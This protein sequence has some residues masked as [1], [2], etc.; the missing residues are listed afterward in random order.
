MQFA[1]ES[2]FRKRLEEATAQLE[3]HQRSV[4]LNN[5]YRV[6]SFLMVF[7]MFFLLKGLHMTLA[8]V[9][10]FLMLIAFVFL[11][12]RSAELVE[13]VAFAKS[14]IQFLQIQLRTIAGDNSEVEDGKEYS[15]PDHDF[16]YDLDMFGSGSV[17]QMI[18]R[19]RLRTGKS[20]LANWLTHNETDPEVICSRQDAIQE[21]SE[22]LPWCEE[23]YA[24]ADVANESDDQLSQL[25]S[26]SKSKLAYQPGT[27]EAIAAWLVPVYQVAIL[28]A[29]LLDYLSAG[30]Y[31]VLLLAPLSWIGK[32]IRAINEAYSQ[33]GDQ[34]GALRYY[35]NMFGHT[36]KAEFSSSELSKL[37]QP[38]KEASS[39][40]LGLS[41]IMSAFDNRNNMLMGVILN[42]FLW[43]DIRCLLKLDRWQQEHGNAIEGWLNNLGEWEA[44][45]SFGVFAYTFAE[46]LHYP[47]P[48]KDRLSIQKVGHPLMLTRKRVDNDFSTEYGDFSII[49]GANMAGK[50]TFLRTLGVNMILAMAGAP[51]LAESFSFR[52][53]KLYSSM[54]TSDSLQSDESYFYNELKR[55]KVLIDKLESGEE[56][57]IILDEILKGTNSK[58]K[59]EGSFRFVEKLLQ[60]KASGVVA[61]HDLSL[62]ELENHHRTRIH[63]L[64]FDVE[65]RNDDLYFDYTLR[66]G[67]CSNMNATFLMKKMNIV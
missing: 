43:W 8:I 41:K 65:I 64:F 37:Q 14:V 60:Y 44:L 59:A 13:R 58:D 39:A 7:G 57:F 6:V 51:V 3:R 36:Q 21:L 45:S 63:N 10:A 34:E 48:K 40:L 61:T 26:W 47:N 67:I 12:R 11:V 1:S 54:R 27:A 52:P 49:T 56:R 35:A 25:L 9:V 22:N 17:F 46:S 24:H 29:Y 38:G 23:L 19:A 4:L 16:A 15:N 31:T 2:Y 20:R 55:L 50:S 33:M 42:L 32:N 62:C 28:S 30:W 5:T 53:V 18:S 66:P